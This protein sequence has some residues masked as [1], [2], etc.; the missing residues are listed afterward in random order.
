MSKVSERFTP[1]YY[2]EGYWER[3][4]G[5][6]YRNY[7]DDAGWNYILSVMEKFGYR[8]GTRIVEAACSKGWF[9]QHALERGWDAFGF[10][11]SP[12]AIGKAPFP[13]NRAVYV[14]DAIDPWPYKAESADIVAGWEF[15]EHIHD[16]NIDAVLEN[17]V[18]ALKPGGELWLK[19]GIIIPED[20]PFAGQEDNDHTHVSVHD[21]AWWEAKFDKLGLVRNNEAEAALDEAF[22]TRDWFGR[23]FVWRKPSD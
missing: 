19:T 16:H 9:I 14:W 5:S 6:N 4:E 23:F 8:E 20:H 22:A 13:A 18:A 21:R 10:D 15:L 2:G 12:Y 1:E 11:L 17:A 3:A 7:G